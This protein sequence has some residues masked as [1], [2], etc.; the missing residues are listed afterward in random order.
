MVSLHI[1][2]IIYDY[3]KLDTC[4]GIVTYEQYNIQLH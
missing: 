2:N 1:V 3:I 4:Y